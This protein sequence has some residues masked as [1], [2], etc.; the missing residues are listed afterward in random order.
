[1]VEHRVDVGWKYAL[2]V[3]V[4]VYG[5]ICP[6]Q[7]G[8]RQFGAVVELHV[9]FQIGTTWAQCETCHSFLMEHTLHFVHPYR[10]TA[11]FLLFDGAIHLHESARTMVLRPVE[12]DTSRNPR[13]RQSNECRFDDMVIIN[14][15]ALFDFVVCH[16]HT[17]TQFGQNHHFDI[18]VF[19]P[20][21]MVGVVGFFV[22]NR[23][24]HRVWIHHTARTLIHS[25]FQENWILL[26]SP[27][28]I[29]WDDN[30][31][32]PSFYHSYF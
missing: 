20:H 3:V 5:W 23:L 19:Q 17:S 15:M 30:I 2:V 22:C 7:E 32:S 24:N 21:S 1:M 10:H 8:L 12:F 18:F 13:T 4:H 25:L 16:L 9:D 14:E 28:F 11:I 29:R 6:P 27:T 31:F 26:V